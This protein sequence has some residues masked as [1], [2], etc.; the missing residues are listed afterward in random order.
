MLVL[1][2]LID[3]AVMIGD[4]IEIVV[5]SAHNGKV[6]IGIQAPAE[7]SVHRIEIYE[8][9]QAQGEPGGGASAPDAPALPRRRAS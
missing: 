5:L 4:D 9:I 6:R 8:A 3:E 2:R 1:T 7:V